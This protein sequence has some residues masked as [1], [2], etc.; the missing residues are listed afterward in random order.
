MRV[1]VGVCG[2]TAGPFAQGRLAPRDSEARGRPA[3]PRALCDSA[4]VHRGQGTHRAALDFAQHEPSSFPEGKPRLAR[5]DS[6]GSK[7][8]GPCPG[9]EGPP[10]ALSQPRTRRGFERR[11]V[12]AGWIQ[13]SAALRV[14]G[15]LAPGL[16]WEARQQHPRQ[17]T[18]G[19]REP[20]CSQSSVQR[21]RAGLRAWPLGPAHSPAASQTSRTL[22]GPELSPEDREVTAVPS[23]RVAVRGEPAR[24]GPVLSPGL[25]LPCAMP[26]A[27][28][29]RAPCTARVP[30]PRGSEPSTLWLGSTL[31]FGQPLSQPVPPQPLL[32][33]PS[34]SVVPSCGKPSLT[35]P[36]PPSQSKATLPCGPSTGA[37]T[38]VPG[39]RWATGLHCQAGIALTAARWSPLSP[40]PRGVPSGASR[41][42]CSCS[43]G[44]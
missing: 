30:G 22:P 27:A 17:S 20:L 26:S 43:E 44:G 42:A 3:R 4:S 19:C 41:V 5:G 8:P 16:Q 12:R 36:R 6:H 29:G 10:P 13:A 23:Y 15:G 40:Q 35:P 37:V 34:S 24:A 33:L 28:G 39:T 31:A 38:S 32:V 14:P 21:G 7:R 18:P 2:A 1:Q 11:P 25:E 9:R